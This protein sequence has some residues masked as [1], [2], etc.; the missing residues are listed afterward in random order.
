VKRLP[1]DTLKID[2]AFVDGVTLDRDDRA[3][4]AAAVGL[5]EALELRVVAEGVETTEQ[6]VELGALGCR[7]GQGFLYS[8]A[9]PPADFLAH[10]RRPVVA[11]R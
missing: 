6:A 7:L 1:I 9:V 4:V 2:R 5:G 10:C 3:I 8:P 11:T